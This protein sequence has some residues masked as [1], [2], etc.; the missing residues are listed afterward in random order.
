MNLFLNTPSEDLIRFVTVK[1]TKKNLIKPDI[2]NSFDTRQSVDVVRDMLACLSPDMPYQDW[3]NVGMALH[4]GGYDVSLWDEWSARGATYKPSECR[5]KWAGFAHGGGVSMGTL[6]HMARQNGYRQ[7]KP[8]EK[9]NEKQKKRLPIYHSSE[10]GSLPKRRY[11]IKGLLEQGGMSVIYGASNSGK[12]FLAIDISYHIALGRKWQDKNTKAGTVVYIYAEGERG[13]Q[14]RL[15][16]FRKHCEIEGYA[17]IYI[18]PTNVCLCGEGN[19]LETLISTI[20]HIPDIKMIVFDTLARALGGGDENS[21][22]DMG[23][24]I[25]NCDFI[26]ERTKAHV[27]IIHHSGKDETRGARGSNALKGAIDTEVQVTQDSGIISA[28]I[29]KQR[30]GMTGHVFAFT[31]QTYEVDIDEDG[32]AVISC[33]LANA[34]LPQRKYVLNGGAHKAWQCLIDL[35][36]EAGTDYTPRKG[37]KPQ[38][39]VRIDDFKAHFIKANICKSD[40]PDSVNKA[41]ARYREIMQ[42]QGYS[43]EWENYIWL[44]DRSDK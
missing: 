29:T 14:E 1:H 33:A 40:K 17:D 39:V 42:S 24:F 26:R 11:L 20:A 37:M 36:L 27:M 4:A 18:I 38:K 31:L 16:A 10:L 30:D 21:A 5:D 44:T 8:V 32:E 6:V 34:D 22:K 7:Q 28:K 9:N 12:T 19:D 25:Q 41:F 3:L 35:I 2:Q 23:A 15:T 13:I 43:A